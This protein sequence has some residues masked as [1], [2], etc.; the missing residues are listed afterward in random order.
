MKPVR[1]KRAKYTPEQVESVAEKLR[2]MPPVEQEKKNPDL[3]KQEAI[4]ALSKD[5]R[6]MQKRGYTLEMIA[7]ILK[8][9][10]ITVSVATLRNYLQ[11]Q[12]GRPSETTRRSRRSVVDAPETAQAE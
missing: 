1:Q 5:I 6:A 8:D 3:S 12:R 11:A 10:N 4:K 2:S 9:E 7:S